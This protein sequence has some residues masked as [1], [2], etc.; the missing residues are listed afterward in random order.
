MPA[1]RDSRASAADRKARRFPVSAT[2]L[3]CLLAGPVSAHEPA[4][5]N[6]TLVP[7]DSGYAATYSTAG[8]IDRTGPFFQALGTNG[9]SCASCHDAADGWTITPQRPAGARRPVG[10]HRPG[11]PDGR[12]GEFAAGRC[13]DADV[14]GAAHTAMLLEQGADPRRHRDPAPVPSSTSS[15]STTPTDTRVRTN[16][17]SFGGPLPATNLGFLSAVM[18]DGRE[19]FKNAGSGDCVV[20]TTNCFASLRVRPLGP[21]ERS[22]AGSRAGGWRRCQTAQR[23]GH[24]RVR[25]RSAT[26]RRSSTATRG[27]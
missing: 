22:D 16:C 18:W 11:L 14:R 7:D 19:T 2:L 1:I 21:G 13:V 24:R 9:R 6:R 27:C 10:R 26:R 25:E 5:M 4:L 20:G 15:R 3:A 12:R 8:V 23:D 17:R